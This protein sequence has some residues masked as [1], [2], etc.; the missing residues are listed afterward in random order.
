MVS[1]V[2][3]IENAVARAMSRFGGQGGD[4]N[5]TMELDGDVVYRKVVKRNKEH[6]DATGKNEFIY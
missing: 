5:I 1:P 2:S 3:E 6:V 4:I